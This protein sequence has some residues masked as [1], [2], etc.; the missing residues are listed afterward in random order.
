M[1]RPSTLAPGLH[2]LPPVGR[3]PPARRERALE[4]HLDDRVPLLLGHVGEHPVPQ[5]AGV[6]DHD[7]QV[8]ERLDR[9]VD[10]PLG[11]L[12][13]R[14]VVAVG[15]RLAAHPLDLLD[16]VLRRAEVAA[17]AVDVATE[18]VH[19]HLGALASQRQRVLAPD[20]AA[21]S[22]HDGDA[23]LT[24]PGHGRAS[25]PRHRARR[26]CEPARWT[27]RRTRSRV[28]S[29]GAGAWLPSVGCASSTGRRASRG[30]LPW[31]SGP[32]ARP[33]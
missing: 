33:R 12:P 30:V 10:Q 22:R 26:T 27:P 4:V 24:D 31:P 2:L 1:M 7:V 18:V 28:R 16:H 8:A 13:R 17:G 9:G 20:A 3:G 14:D 29:Q 15:D 5:D 11:A 21:G 23:S 25:C 32:A 6:V 19:D